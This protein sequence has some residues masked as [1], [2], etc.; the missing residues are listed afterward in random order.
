[1]FGEY[2][3]LGMSRHSPVVR[4]N[5]TCTCSA[6]F[7]IARPRS[8]FSADIQHVLSRICNL[9]RSQIQCS[10]CMHLH[11]IM[12]ARSVTQPYYACSTWLRSYEELVLVRRSCSRWSP[13][14]S[15]R[16]RIDRHLLQQTI[17]FRTLHLDIS[18][19]AILHLTRSLQLSKCQ[20][21][22]LDL[23]ILG[24]LRF[25]Y[26]ILCALDCLS[27]GCSICICIGL[28]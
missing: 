28:P 21:Y 2:R 24:R 25:G 16:W 17:C 19:N 18:R 3:Y 10:T 20:S 5:Q 22:R 4:M 15:S 7:H 27:I 13:S 14:S 8:A 23:Y 11:I 12:T 6:I 26:P 1:M 9:E